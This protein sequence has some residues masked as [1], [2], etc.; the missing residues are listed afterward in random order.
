MWHGT[1]WFYHGLN[2]CGI[3]T[4]LS[5]VTQTTWEKYKAKVKSGELNNGD[6]L[7]Y[8]ENETSS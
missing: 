3:A 8:P 6:L 2:H 7:W 4:L 5:K 1:G